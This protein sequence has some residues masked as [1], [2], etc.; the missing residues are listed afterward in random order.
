MVKGERQANNM[1]PSEINA[2]GSLLLEA[3]RQSIQCQLAQA[4]AFRE[5]VAQFQ[6]FNEEVEAEK[7][8]SALLIDSL[9]AK[10]MAIR[11]ENADLRKAARKPRKLTKREQAIEATRRG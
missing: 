1:K 11:Q 3:A 4:R 10:Y 7:A 8:A 2:I 6:L 5:N 9:K